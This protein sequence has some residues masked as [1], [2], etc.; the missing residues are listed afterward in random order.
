MPSPRCLLTRVRPNDGTHTQITKWIRQFFPQET[1]AHAMVQSSALEKVGPELLTLYEVA[2]YD[3]DRRTLDRAID[4][5]NNVNGEVETLDPPIAPGGGRCVSGGRGRVEHR[6]GR[7]VNTKAKER[8]A[9]LDQMLT[10]RASIA[11]SER[12]ATAPRHLGPIA[13]QANLYAE[14]VALRAKHYDEAKAQGL[15]LVRLDP[16][17]IRATKF[18]NRDDR[19]L[20]VHDPNFVKLSKS[21]AANGQETPIRVR[22]V[23]NALPFEFEIIA[24]HR[25]HAACLALDVATAGGFPIVAMVDAAA[26]ETRDLVL[27]MYRENAEREDLSAHETGMMFRQWLATKVFATQEAISVATGQ[28]KQNVGKYIAL[29]S[30]P[31][32][33]LAAFRDPRVLSLRWSTDL[34]AACE[35]RGATLKALAEEIATRKPAP[36]AESVFAELIAAAPKK[37]SGTASASESIKEGNK[38]LFELSAREGRYGI[39]LGKH[40]DKRLRKE[41]QRDLKEWLHAWI[42]AR[43]PEVPK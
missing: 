5:M 2:E 6:G 12:P 41:L 21:L 36:A 22:P 29:A 18:K 15:L 32:Y 26:D 20:L 39:R 33:I 27:K 16:K 43:S 38:V 1:C 31:D 37:K 14:H 13:E 8:R 42:K 23:K 25:R 40:V 11:P 10:A 34:T 30:L 7:G 19:S 28:S 4:A 24:G 17:K 9:V 3:G 35:A